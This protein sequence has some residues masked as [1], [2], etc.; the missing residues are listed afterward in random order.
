MPN[1]LD[2]VVLKFGSSVL[3]SEEDLP[4]AVHEIYRWWRD[5]VKVFAVV[6]AFGDTTNN[7][8]G[9][10]D[11]VGGPLDSTILASLLAT[12]EA[13][14]SALLGLSLNKFGIPAHVL[15]AT[16]AGLR[17]SGD[18]L[19][20][21]L[22]SVDVKALTEAAQHGVVVLPG[23]V[24]RNDAG[25]IALLGRGGSDYSALFLANQL[26]AHCVLLKDVDGLYTSDPSCN[27]QR[28]I[29]FARVSYDTA[30][31][32]GGELV[33]Q[34][35]IRFA[36]DHRLKFSITSI[37]ASDYTE[38]GPFSDRLDVQKPDY[39]AL[40]V[41]LLGCG[42]VGGGVYQLLN[43]L[44]D[45]FTIVGVG[46]RTPQRAFQLGVP[47]QLIT[48]DVDRLLDKHCDV[49]V[50]LIGGLTQAAS[51]TSRAL[52]LGRD[53]VTAN[54]SLI[55]LNGDSLH[56]LADKTGAR[57][58]YSAAV[59]GVLPA[60][61]TIERVRD[62]GSIRAFSGVLNATTNFVLDQ[63]GNGESIESA[64]KLAQTH[65][66]A[67]A[68]PQADLDGTDAAQ[69]LAILARAAFGVSLS[70]QN[71]RRKGIIGI[72]TDDV[73]NT[74]KRGN[75]IRLVASAELVDG[76]IETSVCPLS[77]PFDHPLSGV[78][79]TQNRL[80][81]AVDG[82]EQTVVSGEGAGRWP[83]SVAVIADLLDCRTAQ[84]QSQLTE[85]VA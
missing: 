7:L 11:K 40:K 69:K 65:G 29:R 60:I 81:V 41:T 84:A 27:S 43:E 61:E 64:V 34:K 76:R 77:L 85:C 45:L 18:Q 49:V 55:A 47:E 50:E 2:S 16:Q 3:Q 68:D 63:L 58:R 30:A 37:G 53:V 12:G 52:S 75:S 33:Q 31:R 74:S 59:G 6:S 80:L 4:R 9:L 82:G 51:L 78:S 24:G 44:P 13:A 26:S 66:Y 73:C 71:I 42:T 20:G 28:A 46:T 14:S 17:T 79:G 39:E 8:K 21:Q 36:S 38:V 83:T 32:L 15:D 22:A 19:D 62:T 23:F 72:T 54:K 57:L 70:F 1:Q 67:E 5:G 10:A 48:I 25:A 35:A 56:D